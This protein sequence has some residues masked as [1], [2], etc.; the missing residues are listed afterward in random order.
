[1]LA[2]LLLPLLVLL[3]EAQTTAANDGNTIIAKENQ[4]TLFSKPIS[5]KPGHVF[6][7]HIDIEFPP[8]IIGITAFGA[9]LVHHGGERDGQPVPLS[10]TY[11][12]HWTVQ[13]RHKHNSGFCWEV[14]PAPLTLEYLLGVGS[15][16]RR[17]TAD[18]P[19]P[20]ALV[21]DDRDTWWVDLHAIDLRNTVDSLACRECL[22]TEFPPRSDLPED[23]IGG[24]DCCV[25]DSTPCRVTNETGAVMDY[26]L[27]YNVT[28]VEGKELEERTPVEMFVMDVTGVF[29]RKNE[30][31]CF[32]EYDVPHPPSAYRHDGSNPLPPV[33]FGEIL[34]VN[35]SSNSSIEYDDDYFTL[36]S[37][38][39][40]DHSGRVVL[41]IPHLHSGANFA[42][43]RRKATG[44]LVCR[45][46]ALY[47]QGSTPGDE[48]GFVVEITTCREG[49]SVTR[50]EEFSF[51]V[52]YNTTGGL[53]EGYSPV[54]H[55]GVMGYM[56]MAL[57][58]DDVKR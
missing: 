28:W 47:G 34:G 26:K 46:D 54:A 9:D 20:Y 16:S 37:T 17:T 24:L 21:V 44:E 8:G 6:R 10:H 32:I 31:H 29:D 48:K 12:H 7:D 13:Q 3:R 41:A 22:C 56:W 49:W 4:K 42:E 27:R 39:S 18:F 1:M 5:L 55:T 25:G 43:V 57:T 38:F 50:D 35:N 2:S 14:T 36:K 52:Q 11:L 45:G 30:S 40:F 23:Y 33:S 19:P 53:D 15:E 51:S 58:F